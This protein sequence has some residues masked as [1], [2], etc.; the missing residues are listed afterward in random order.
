[1]IS[2]APILLLVVIP[3]I[4]LLLSLTRWRRT[5]QWLLVVV[6]MLI[7]WPIELVSRSLLPD[8]ISYSWQPKILF[9]LSPV[10]LM[11]GVSWSFSMALITLGLA[12]VLTA[13]A[14]I[15]QTEPLVDQG[16]STNLRDVSNRITASN[17]P[18]WAGSLLIISAGLLAVQS[19]NLLT[20][21]L[22]WATIDIIELV[23]LLVEVKDSPG[24]EQAITAF[25]IRAAGI[26]VLILAQIQIWQ[27]DRI[28]NLSSVSSQSALYL[29]IAAALRLGVIPLH[30]SF[31]QDVTLRRSLGTILRLIP[32]AASLSLLVRAAASGVEYSVA[33]Y[34]LIL[35]AVAGLVGAGLWAFSS[36]ELAGR[37]Y[38]ILGTASMATASAVLGQPAACLGWGIASILI[39]GLLFFTSL[40]HRLMRI[41]AIIGFLGLSGL[42]FTPNWAG[43]LFYTVLGRDLPIWQFVLLYILFIAAHALLITGFL[44]FSLRDTLLPGDNPRDP[45][46]E[47]W[48]WLV[49]PIGLTVLPLTQFLIGFWSL[50]DYQNIPPVAYFSGLATSALGFGLWYVFQN[51]YLYKIAQ[52]SLSIN[53]VP[54]DILVFSWLYKLI[55][56]IY[57]QFQ[58][59]STLA[60]SF[61]EG[62]GGILWAVVLF[63][64]ILMWLS[65]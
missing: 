37:P 60:Y 42:P 35:C 59:L 48:I 56:Y 22:A 54:S 21:L 36:D 51:A 13:V 1:M 23:I 33:L 65:R 16:L 34:L 24:R 45:Q 10:L 19:G 5:S 27:S 9:P 26:G 15:E 3:I 38:W 46:V 50:P 17:M 7:I 64:F 30:L 61:L 2:L 58:R 55:W 29:L 25:S 62:D 6:G 57:T 31:Y 39:G 14:R 32:A 63:F 12:L 49:Y 52:P 47:R 43:V 40:R 41:I 53:H 4:M 18:T 28:S 20:V 8:S 44:R 11:D